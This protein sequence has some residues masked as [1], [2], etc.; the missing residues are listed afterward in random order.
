MSEFPLRM[1]DMS[2]QLKISYLDVG[3]GPQTL[4]FVHGMDSNQKA[5]R[6][7]I[8]H[9]QSSFRCISLDLPNHG[10]SSKGRFPFTPA[11]FSGLLCD[12]IDRLRLS[13]PVL[14]GHSMG[15]QAVLRALIDHP[16]RF[17]RAVLIAP[18][19]L[20]TFETQ[21]IGGLERI[22]T[23]ESIR[24]LRPEQ[25]K[26]NVA[27]FFYEMPTDAAFML[28]DRLALRESPDFALHCEMIP[29]CVLGMVN[30]PVNAELGR[31]SAEVLVLFGEDDH[32]IPHP[33]FHSHESTTEMA[34]R[35][36]AKIPNAQLHLFPKTGHFLQWE[37]AQPF[38]ELVKQFLGREKGQASNGS[39]GFRSSN[40][41]E[42]DNAQLDK[43]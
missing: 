42:S 39:S 23:P 18:A 26:K 25:I 15:G 30:N 9:L 7:N 37:Q 38:N 43:P 6:K 11:F 1:I 13:R 17:E 24:D 12:F 33:K 32:L 41:T 36:S 20:E 2:D 8:P 16:Q 21:A 31:I 14:V 40:D 34:R 3:A 28:E 19:G 27:R 35:E 4:V 29:N 5:W 10:A 22:Y